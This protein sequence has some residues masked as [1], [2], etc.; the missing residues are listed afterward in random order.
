MEI[1]KRI[2]FLLLALYSLV[3]IILVYLS[4]EIIKILATEEYYEA[5]Y[6]MPPIAGGVFFISVSNMFSNILIYL[7]KTKYIMISAFIAA[8][9]N[10]VSNY[11]FIKFY[12]YM[13]AAYTTLF[14]YIIMTVSLFLFA[15]MCGKHA[16]I[17]ISDFYAN[18]K[19][20]I[21]SIITTLLCLVGIILYEFTVIRYIITALLLTGGIGFLC[22]C[23]RWNIL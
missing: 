7:K 12:G 3:A 21:L 22:S 4:P 16:N 15:N 19:I 20:C 17:N 18:K 1:I 13:A 14:A 8:F 6:I 11:I 23:K 9:L 5:I 10:L 2:S